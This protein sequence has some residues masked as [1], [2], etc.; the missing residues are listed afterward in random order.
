MIDP[1]I[2]ELIQLHVSYCFNRFH[3]KVILLTCLYYINTLLNLSTI[4][5]L[6]VLLLQGPGTSQTPT[7]DHG[8]SQISQVSLTQASQV[9]IVGKRTRSAKKTTKTSIYL[10]T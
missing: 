3:I 2:T 4:M 6:L 1:K 10:A 9:P 8:G 5:N 7:S